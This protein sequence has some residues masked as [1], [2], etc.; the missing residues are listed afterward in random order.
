MYGCMYV[1][2]FVC[3]NACVCVYACIYAFMYWSNIFVLER[4]LFYQHLYG[5]NNTNGDT[6][7]RVFLNWSTVAIPSE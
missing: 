5:R 1:C 7:L 3:K 6:I 2:M 4:M